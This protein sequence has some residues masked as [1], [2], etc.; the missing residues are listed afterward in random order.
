MKSILIRGLAACAIA[1]TPGVPQAQGTYSSTPVGKLEGRLLVEWVEPDKFI[2]TPDAQRPLTFTRSN[3]VR[4]QP[5]RMY[6]DGGSIPRPLWILR[7]YSPWGYAPAFILH[8]W[9]FEMQHCKKAGFDRFSFPDGAAV[10]AEVMKTMMESG[11]AERDELTLN[12]MYHAVLSPIAR[13][14]WDEGS[15]FPPPIERS[16]PPIRIYVLDF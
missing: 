7:N 3:G 6:T 13:K 4:I 9:L 8:D 12:S 1:C 16:G 11:K 10:L 2:F 5:E 14:H 15:C